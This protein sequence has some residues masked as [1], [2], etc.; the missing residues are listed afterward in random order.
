MQYQYSPSSIPPGDT[1]PYNIPMTFGDF[2]GDGN[3]DIAMPVGNH[4]HRG[5]IWAMATAS[6]VNPWYS[7]INLPSN[8]YILTSY[9]VIVS[10][11]FNHDGQVLTWPL[12]GVNSHCERR[13]GLRSARPGQRA[14]F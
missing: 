9:P 7:E 13:D 4:T 3:I 1:G 2:N 8:Q 14:V 6:F 10:A 11:D 12:V 5:H